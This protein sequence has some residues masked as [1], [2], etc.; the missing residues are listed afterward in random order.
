MVVFQ[1]LLD[2][3][4]MCNSVPSPS[5]RDETSKADLGAFIEARVWSIRLQSLVHQRLPW[6]ISLL[7]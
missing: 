1:F 2:V 6:Q 5:F 3:H 4:S 7:A